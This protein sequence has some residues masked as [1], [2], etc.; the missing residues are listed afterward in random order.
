MAVQTTLSTGLSPT[1]KTFYDKNLLK[2]VKA[3]LV[4]NQFG[5]VRNIPK[6]GGKTIEFRRFVPFEKAT[7]PLTEGVTPEGSSL[8]METKVC[9]VKQYG[10]FVA[11]SDVLE[12][13]ALDKIILETQEAQGTQSAETLDTI[14]AEI[15]NSGTN[16]YYCGGKLSRDSL[17][18]SD[19]LTVEDVRKIVRT[20][21]SNKA[22][23][24]KGNYICICHPY[25]LYDLK[26]DPEWQNVKT[27]AD[28]KDWYNGEI[29]RIEGVRF[30]ETTEAIRFDGEGEDGCN[31]FS[32]LFFGDNAYGRTSIEKGGVE[33]I[34]HPKGSGGTSDPLDQRSTIGWKAIHTACILQ[35]AFI[36]R[37]ESSATDED[38]FSDIGE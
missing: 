7:V 19:V 29:G 12:L 18:P 31:V 38:D 22:Q 34:I 15:L 24:I 20:L 35:D 4:H 26:K 36:V 10:D 6:N 2:N 13:T 9:T 5:Q 17:T 8:S 27:Y 28:P 25:V 37:C 30:L 11:V 14:T 16:V 1:M 33:T 23:K 32:S 21:K 3:V